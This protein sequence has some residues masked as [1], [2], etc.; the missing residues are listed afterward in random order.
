MR[1]NDSVCQNMSVTDK[2]LSGAIDSM[3]T[4]L[5]DWTEM[6]ESAS[7]SLRANT[8]EFRESVG[9]IATATQSLS[10]VITKLENNEKASE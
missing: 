7:A 1:L 6:Q 3:S 2:S 8:E 5:K 10:G 4:A 9:K